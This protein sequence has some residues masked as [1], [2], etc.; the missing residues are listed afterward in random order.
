MK[1][2]RQGRLRHFWLYIVAGLLGSAF[3]GGMNPEPKSTAAPP[4]PSNIKQASGKTKGSSNNFETALKIAALSQQRL[5]Q[6]RDYSCTMIK[7]ERMGRS[8]QPNHIIDLKVR[9]RPFSVNMLW[10]APSSLEG[11]EVCYVQGKHNGKM[12]ARGT[13]LLKALGFVTLD[14]N[15]ARAKKHSNHTIT[16][17]G[18]AN[19][20]AQ[21]IH[22]W[23]LQARYKKAEVKIGEYRFNNRKVVRVETIHQAKIQGVQE[24]YRNVFYFDRQTWLPTRVERYDWPR[25]GGPKGGD[26]FEVYSY[27]N[28]KVNV[29]LPDSTFIK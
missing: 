14:P 12:R 2:S 4:P 21:F 22:S 11:Q 19:L 29:N 16:E 18:I 9:H 17:A 8:L 10:Q 23:K 7:Q 28:M 1:R 15:D 6:V 3:I 13:G 24:N 20:L 26:L 25:Q 27:L 5:A